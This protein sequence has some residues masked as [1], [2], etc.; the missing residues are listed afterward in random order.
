MCPEPGLIS[1]WVDG[2]VPS[3]WKERIA[4]HVATCAGC[5]ARVARYR[6]L[7]GLLSEGA[8]ADESAIVS[9]IEARLGGSLDGLVETPMSAAPSSAAPG[10]PREG[11]DVSLPGHP[12]FWG[13]NI[14]LPLPVAI[15]AGAIFL[16]FAG[17]AA[18]TFIRPAKPAVQTLAASEIKPTD[19]Q[20][21]N[22]E[23]LVHYLESQNAQVNLTIQL[24]SGTTFDSSGKPFVM[25]ATD[26]NYAPFSQADGSSQGSEP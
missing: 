14:P 6:R 7:S 4:A 24:P 1:A 8:P 11:L 25:K 13:R 9:R 3:P 12:R 20:A 2:E 15:A 16:F 10:T 22:M 5:A 18:T 23:A 21:A 19:S 26:A 17:V